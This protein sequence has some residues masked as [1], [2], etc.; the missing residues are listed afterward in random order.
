M[1]TTLAVDD[2]DSRYG[3]LGDHYMRI[4]DTQFYLPP[5]D[6]KVHRMM[7]N[8][9][10]SVMR[11]KN[12]LPK[13]S[14]Y[15]DRVITLTI[16]FPDVRS[17]NDELR[18]L[19]AQSKKCPF[20]P[21]EN[22]YLNDAHKV[23]AITIQNVTVQT[24]PGFPNTLQAII[25]CYAFEP[26]A[27]IYGST[28]KTFDEMFHWPLFRWYYGRH[29][30]KV[31]VVDPVFKQ[32]FGSNSDKQLTY[33]E[34]VSGEVTNDFQFRIV[35]EDDLLAIREWNKEKKELIKAWQEDKNGSSL[36]DFF[37]NAISSKKDGAKPITKKG[38]EQQFNE[39]Y[40]ELYSKAMYE[41]DLHY[42]TWDLGRMELEDFSISF[43]NSI[44]SYQLQMHQS[45]A[46]Q[47]LG[48]QDTV[49]VARFKTDD[50][51]S[52]ASLEDLMRRTSY[53]TREYHKEVSNG[54]LEID[55][56]LARLYGVK[57][58]VID[59]VSINTI[60]GMPGVY[61]ITLTLMAYNRAEKK[62]H[63]VSAMTLGLDWDASGTIVNPYLQNAMAGF[64]KI[65]TSIG[66]Q[67]NAE[68]QA[69]YNEH[70]INAFRAAELY[71]DLELPTY[72]EVREAGFSLINNNNGVF[73][74]PD[75]FIKYDSFQ[76]YAQLLSESIDS[77]S[78][79]I[80]MYDATG[81]TATVTKG[82]LKLDE[83]ADRKVEEMKTITK[84]SVPNLGVSENVNANQDTT[85]R[86]TL[87]ME[88][89]IRKS[90]QVYEIPE[91][92][93]IAFAKAFDSKLRHFYEVG[94]NPELGGI[95][96]SSAG[97]PIFMG[98]NLN[99][100]GGDRSADYAGV[101]RVSNQ[102]GDAKLISKSIEYNVDVGMR[103][104]KYYWEVAG[105]MMEDERINTDRLHQ[106]LDIPNT[107]LDDSY[108]AQFILMSALYLQHDREILAVMNKGQEPRASILRIYEHLLDVLDGTEAWGY[109]KL[110]KEYGKL[111]VQDYKATI[112]TVDDDNP[113]LNIKQSDID[114][115]DTTE[116][117]K[118]MMH[119]M[120]EYDRRG[121]LVRAF[122]TFFMTFIDEGQFVG[123]AKMSDQY[124]HYRA[125]SDITYNN[126][127][128]QA[129]STLVC[130]LSNVFGSLSDSEKAQDLT[131]TSFGDMFLA[132]IMPGAVAKAQERSRHRNSN[133]YK[134]IYLRTGVRVH[135]R[136]G[137][138]AN[139]AE[140][141][142]IMNGTITSLQNN[143]A[144]IT[145]IAQDDGIELTNKLNAMMDI[146]PQDETSG[147]LSSKKEPT[148]II[149]EL[150][151]DSRGLW[152]NISASLSN[153]EYQDH[154]LG[155]MHFGETGLPQGI[156]DFKDLFTLGIMES[157][158]R[159]EVNMNVYQT[160]GLLHE[161]QSK[162][163]NRLKDGLGIGESDEVNININL[164]DKTIWDVL[165]IGASVG[166]DMITAVHPFGL[167]STIFLG[168]PYFPITY[169]YKVDLESEKVV[170][171][172]IKSFKQLHS[173]DSY[174]SIISNGIKATE[175]NMYTVAVGA[176]NNEGKLNV[177]PP[178]YVDS[179]I[180]P[181]KQKTVNIDTTL[182]AKGVAALGAVPFIGDM[183]NKPAKWFFD[184]GVALKITAAGLRDFVKDMYDGYLTVPGDPS[185]KPYDTM[186]L[187]DFYT[188]MV[189]PADMKEII[190]VMNHDVGFI[191]MIKPD[192]IAYNEDQTIFNTI[193]R[194]M[195]VVAYAATRMIAHN[196]LKAKGYTGS[197]PILNAVWSSTKE[198]MGK[199][200]RTFKGTAS[201][202]T[203]RIPQLDIDR[204][205]KNGTFDSLSKSF[206]NVSKKDLEDLLKK[207]QLNAS[208]T[209]KDFNKKYPNLNKKASTVLLKGEKGA[210]K[211]LSG[212]K[213]LGSV[214]K[215]AWKAKHAL[216][217]PAGIVTLAIESVV[218][219][220]LSST[221]GEFTERFLMNRQAVIIVPLKKDG[222]EFTAGING[223][224]G[225][226]ESIPEDLTKFYE[227]LPGPLL[228][229]Y[230]SAESAN[231]ED[232]GA[233]LFSIRSASSQKTVDLSTILNGRISSSHMY[234]DNGLIEEMYKTDVAAA[235]K[236]IAERLEY[237]VSMT[238]EAQNV[239]YTHLQEKDLSAQSIFSNFLNLLFKGS[240]TETEQWD[241]TGSISLNGK[242]VNLSKYFNKL[243]PM[244]D[245]ETER[246]GVPQ[247][248]EILKAKTMQESG[249]NYERYPD[250]MQ[251]SESLGLPRNSIGLSRSLEQGVKYFIQM[252]N[253]AGGDVALAMQAYNYGGGFINYVKER[254]GA[255]TQELANAFSD[256]KASQ[257]G[258][259]RYGDK[260]YIKNIMRYYEYPKGGTDDAPST[261]GS[262]GRSKYRLSLSQAKSQLIEAREANDRKF[263]VTLVGSSTS[264]MRKG[265]FDLLNQIAQDYKKSTGKTIN[266]TSA[267][268]AND[269]NWH[270]TGYGVDID[271]PNTM[272]RLSGGKLG[273]PNGNDKN[274]A[275]KLIEASIKAGFSGIYFGD[276]FIIENMKRKYPKVQFTYEP[277]NHHNH[278]HLSYPLKG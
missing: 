183:L 226:V 25:Q 232:A 236:E 107:S 108:K 277:N 168:K 191:T 228:D 126:S 175:D 90:A 98:S 276:W 65:H 4:G 138:G 64:K 185:V 52:V 71:P 26:A 220:A 205:K 72:D 27:Y 82:G 235:E 254:G 217:G 253:S 274:E 143:G 155:V 101:M 59:D 99:L 118:T 95:Y 18:P 62:M 212:G 133:F 165:N 33:F 54:F 157:R 63:E 127:R 203:N 129:S 61:D 187:Q 21:I 102:Y 116:L 11:G 211:V 120:L 28:E 44:S 231:S 204:W 249:G 79:D 190:H 271:T 50:M 67:Q 252:M 153:K 73:V 222:F 16:F 178:V 196:I 69:I 247:Y 189:G 125:I 256:M 221:V 251:S 19:L 10:V 8:Q 56:Q 151:T 88:A 182:N 163:Y 216:L 145:M 149:D 273:F 87:E 134:S 210:K 242:A 264:L 43:E 1:A 57:S 128:K 225:S 3:V 218:V 161:D 105:S 167:R 267:Y 141:P 84:N 270:G 177:T 112:Y 206:G 83:V 15:F 7:K 77:G 164:Y 248:A 37:K 265:T 171:E 20:L 174:T 9:K 223:N 53:L 109:E 93:P 202:V 5:T 199:A 137:Y 186:L 229:M 245:K 156:A 142:T 70:V 158:D 179:N 214:V 169:G 32:L 136:M 258:W 215:G 91:I 124:F 135:M 166:S 49:I 48:S 255:W 192:V 97:S 66:I 260:N 230:I 263:N 278:L 213:A 2:R 159:A 152:S 130:E 45:P 106:M 140:L 12:S 233:R 22:T 47:Y 188:D 197:F 114:I 266:I 181:E 41:Y 237:L 180:W 75:F 240:D 17:I 46:H 176:Y 272:R 31:K 29:L 200:H 131:H 113:T 38:K 122:P 81:G 207:G 60:E 55:H 24:T 89:L 34:P 269:P 250:V 147:F 243:G 13:E 6:I 123:S 94:D 14:G 68:Q 208:K 74:D 30:K 39:E 119:D 275:V 261:I 76:D 219:S 198:K 259:K 111:K 194:A 257:L 104:M 40:D 148:E 162:W 238:Q 268:R 100:L 58:V 246:Q 173:Y 92:Y 154:A 146:D 150:L 193:A 78:S 115:E 23:E 85:N 42:E 144:T 241:G 121:R 36:G 132:S 160:T 244:I 86:S 117:E 170:G 110:Q 234:K 209:I 51:E 224:K 262:E 184:E 103:Y 239:Q 201:K 172:K 80:K 227:H 195:T 96:N 35:A 139:A